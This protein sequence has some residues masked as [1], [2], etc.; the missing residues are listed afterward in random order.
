[1]WFQTLRD[2]QTTTLNIKQ[3]IVS[4]HDALIIIIMGIELRTILFFYNLIIGI[5]NWKKT[6]CHKSETFRLVLTYRAVYHYNQHTRVLVLIQK[7]SKFLLQ[8]LWQSFPTNSKIS[9][10]Y[11]PK[12][13]LHKFP[14][15]LGEKK[16]LQQSELHH[17]PRI[18]GDYVAQHPL[19]H[20][21]LETNYD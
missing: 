18:S 4:H 8:T 12:K 9:L 21:P 15:F 13:I 2:H 5:G 6:L 14:I 19:V 20:H 1:M 17:K 7:N 3:E 10:I 16:S 11:T